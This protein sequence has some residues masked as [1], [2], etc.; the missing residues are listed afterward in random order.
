MRFI[1][2]HD[3]DDGDHD[4]HSVVVAKPAMTRSQRRLLRHLSH[5]GELSPDAEGEIGCA[6]AALDAVIRS[7]IRRGWAEDR[8]EHGCSFLAVTVAGRS[9]LAAVN[10]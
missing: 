10:N 9:A 7:A 5:W 3:V 2:S 1:G 4:T 8:T 6:G